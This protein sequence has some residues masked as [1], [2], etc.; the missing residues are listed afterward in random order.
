MRFY[1]LTKE[2]KKKNVIIPD[3]N[4]WVR[5]QTP[6]SATGDFSDF[7][8]PTRSL[9]IFYVV[10]EIASVCNQDWPWT[11]LKEKLDVSVDSSVSDDCKTPRRK[12]NRS[13]W[14]SSM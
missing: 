1:H 4:K 11:W 8:F 6:K 5:N 9:P 13:P 10:I 7:P 12:R 14:D 3:D 2:K